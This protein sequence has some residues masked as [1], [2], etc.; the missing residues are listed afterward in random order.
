[1]EISSLRKDKDE[2]ARAL[3]ETVYGLLQYH[4]QVTA[5]DVQ[6][7]SHQAASSSWSK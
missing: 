3:G 2:A 4:G 1:M 6:E 5:D 7:A